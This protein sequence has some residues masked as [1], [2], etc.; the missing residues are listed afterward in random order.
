MKRIVNSHIAFWVLLSIPAAWMVWDYA[1]GVMFYGGFIHASGDWSVRLL[2]ATMAVTP[3]RLMFPHATWP[4]WLMKRRRHLGVASFGYALLHTLV[5]LLRKGDMDLIVTEGI[6]PD[7]L[8]GWIA[9][10]IFTVLALTS[11]DSSSRYLGRAWKRLH[12]FVYAA[13]ILTF[14]HWLL[15]AFDIGPA[16]VYAGILVVL[17]VV[18]I[19]LTRRRAKRVSIPSST[20]AGL[21]GETV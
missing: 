19:F 12:R 11:N 10:A 2:I 3:L 5:Y 14:A 13:A 16:L 6:E 1:T 18:R 4:A 20:S 8:T 15:T 7:L 21:N 9:L 17:E